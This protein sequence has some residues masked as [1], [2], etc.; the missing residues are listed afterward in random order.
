MWWPP[1]LFLAAATLVLP[2]P[3][4]CQAGEE[5][6]IVPGEKTAAKAPPANRTGEDDSLKVH[7][8]PLRADVDLVLVP[9]TVTDTMN[10]PVTGL[11]KADFALYEDGSPQE[12]RAF[13]SDDS[14]IS[15]GVILD[16]SK[17]M[18]NKLDVAREALGKFF[19]LGNPEDDYFVITFADRPTLL[20]DT[21]QSI[22]SI[23]GRLAEAVAGGHT[24]LL[25]AI[26]L[27]EARLRKSRYKRRA[28]LIIS[29]GG[30]NRSRFTARELK[31][32]VEEEDATL[33]AIGLFDRVFKTPEEWAGKRLLTQITEATG[34]RT[35]SLNNPRELPQAASEISVEMRNQ[36]VL[37]YRPT[38]RMHNGKWR[39]IKVRAN[40]PTKTAQLQVYSKSG[41]RAP[42]E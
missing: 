22:G 40:L 12:I 42:E 37:G 15:V 17:S 36:Y 14:P 25:D 20:A 24:A 1:L 29:D 27:G 21:T 38:N 23:R 4:Y 26:Y 30:D 6:H 31:S 8:K 28:L 11:S 34:G 9:V 19:E 16:L 18:S 41:Y 3:S 39:K 5:V 32:M 7:S 2:P 13:W 10:R 33:Y 35:L